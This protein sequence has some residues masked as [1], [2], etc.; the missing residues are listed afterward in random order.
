[1][2]WSAVGPSWIGSIKLRVLIILK[3]DGLY[4]GEVRVGNAEVSSGRGN[5]RSF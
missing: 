5:F 2:A 3:S 1:M 4:C